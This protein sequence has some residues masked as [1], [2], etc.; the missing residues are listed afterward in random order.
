[1][2]VCASF[3][4][5]IRKGAAYVLL[6]LG[7]GLGAAFTSLS[8]GCGPAAEPPAAPKPCDVQIV[9]LRI[10]AADNINPNENRN[11]RPVVVRLYQLKNEMRLQNATYDEV[12][13]SDKEVLADDI[14][15]MDEVSVF[16]NDLVEVKFER[17]ERGERARRRRA[18]PQPQRAELEDVLRSSP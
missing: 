7:L 5:R 15:K 1:M 10:Y 9:T 4:S 12:L 17:V 6:G 2:A 14:V 13:L 18:L 8:T 11:P 3:P 16:P